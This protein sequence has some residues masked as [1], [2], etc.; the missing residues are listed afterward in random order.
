MI[1]TAVIKNEF[2]RIR[3]NSAY[4]YLA[5]GAAA[6]AYTAVGVMRSPLGVMSLSA[7]RWAAAL[8]SS[9]SALFLFYI[10][11]RKPERSVFWA[12]KNL[13][14]I[15]A[16][17]LPVFLEGSFFNVNR[18]E[19]YSQNFFGSF[20]P[21]WGALWWGSMAV[22]YI[23]MRAVETSHR[24]G[25]AHG[26]L[27][28][29][30]MCDLAAMYT[31]QKLIS[32][33]KRPGRGK[34]VWP[35]VCMVLIALAVFLLTVTVFLRTVYSNMEFEAIL[36]TVTF[37]AGG[38]AAEDLIQGFT[39]VVFFSL[40]TGYLCRHL[41]KCFLN[42][43]L[44]VAHNN[45][46]GKY[47]LVMDGKK[48]AMQIALSA[49]ML[50]G[51]FAMFSGQTHFMHYIGM[52]QERSSIYD[53]Y[54]VSPDESVVSFPGEKRNLIFIFLESIE[55][56]YASREE[57]GS[58]ER[59]YIS[60]L[61]A[62]TREGDC[63]NFSNTDRLGGASVFVPSITYTQ[64][65]TV[66][67]TSGIALNTQL[68]QFYTDPEF[69]A[70]RRLEDVLHDNGYEQLY[71]EGSKGEFSL[72]DKYVGRYD[73]SR[74]FD[75]RTAEEEGFTDESEDYIWK[76]GI[77]DSKLVEI[78]K[79]LITEMSRKDKPFFVT[80]YTMDTH[81]FESGHR[82]QDCDSGI[83]NDYL[84][85]VD[86]SSRRI[87]GLVD[88]IRQQPFFEN[89]TVILVGDHLGNQKTMNVDIDEGYVRTTYNCFINPAKKPEKT[90][91]RIFSSLD[92]FP[93]TLSA[94]GAEIKG[95]R[96]GLGTDLF[97]GTKTLCEELGEE[98]YK[99]QLERSSE[100]YEKVFFGLP[101]ETE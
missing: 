43:E 84:A 36:F 27:T 60:E 46:E 101:G 59:N 29:R 58:Q 10:L 33:R 25:I 95:D 94:I 97:S 70:V 18:A 85:A 4:H 66:A 49:A 47:T 44:V 96:L 7:V 23:L 100:Y 68:S 32:K 77:E 82:C 34:W 38:L 8:F 13:Y 41:F 6:L 64:G 74:V 55:N 87:A 26:D 75:R 57:G 45:S 79:E 63:V 98:E 71:I 35:S 31:P 20:M 69:P 93:T 52:K 76:W 65:S 88:W 15:A 56:T 90:E 50:I 1:I 80:M 91:G 3:E 37:A 17:L 16:P 22:L 62:L 24:R 67:Q 42:D 99:I 21:G 12:A 83:L 5:A 40:I 28:A 11:V 72:Y 19:V 89:T 9:L 61:T 30:F 53:R 51:C 2:V 81:T 39:L 92:M 86:C 48:R 14:C 73:N 54:Y 78:T